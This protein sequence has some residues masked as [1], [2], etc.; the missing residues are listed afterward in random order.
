LLQDGVFSNF[1]H[2]LTIALTFDNFQQQ[3]SPGGE[4][5]VKKPKKRKE[6]AGQEEEEEGGKRSK[7][8]DFEAFAGQVC[9]CVCDA[10]LFVC[11]CVCC[12]MCRYY[13]RTLSRTHAHIPLTLK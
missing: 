9:V 10:Y 12:V 3:E 13:T 4:E 6:A 1:S 5:E 7:P 2:G 11:V 8:K